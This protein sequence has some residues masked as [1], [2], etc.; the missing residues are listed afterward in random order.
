MWEA[1]E[2]ENGLNKDAERDMN[3]EMQETDRL[4]AGEN[5]QPWGGA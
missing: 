4:G 2:K 1:L 5:H 3:M